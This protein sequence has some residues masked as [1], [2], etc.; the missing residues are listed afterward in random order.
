MVYPINSGVNNYPYQYNQYSQSTT[1]TVTSNP[2]TYTDPSNPNQID[3]MNPQAAVQ[4]VLGNFSL[5]DTAYTGQ[6]SNPSPDGLFAMSDVQALLQ[7]NQNLPSNVQAAAQYLENN[8][9]LFQSLDTAAQGG[10]ADGLASQ[11][12]LQSW[13]S[14]NQ[15]QSTT[16]SSYG[17]ATQPYSYAGS[18]STNTATNP[19]LTSTESPS[20]PFSAFGINTNTTNPFTLQPIASTAAT[21]NTSTN[22]FM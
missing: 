16:A 11:Q 7:N 5:F 14:T 9:A 13:L 12:D 2:M 22:F 15:Q 17:N 3:Q 19:Y 10:N 1:P 20:N 18:T 8:P 6:G 21:T 4:T